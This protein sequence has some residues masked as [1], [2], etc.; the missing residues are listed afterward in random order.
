MSLLKRD[1][2]NSSLACFAS[3][4]V[5]KL[6]WL[7]FQS[8]FVRNE[9][10]CPNFSN[11][12]RSSS[13]SRE[14][15]KARPCQSLMHK[16]SKSGHLPQ[17]KMEKMPNDTPCGC[18]PDTSRGCCGFF[19]VELDVPL[20]SISESFASKPPTMTFFPPHNRVKGQP[21]NPVFRKKPDF[22]SRPQGGFNRKEHRDST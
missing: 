7:F 3:C 11:K 14:V 20:H 13:S 16:Q 19:L 4:V 9:V 1:L 8:R 12:C 2:S 22:F 6:I 21:G 18:S 15:A 17:E 5:E 10:T